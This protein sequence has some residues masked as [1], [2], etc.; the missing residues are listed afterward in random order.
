MTGDSGKGKLGKI[1]HYYKCF[2]KKKNKQICD[3]KS[4]SKD[5]LEEIVIKATQEFM[6]HTNL[7]AIAKAITDTYNKDIEKDKI[8][9]SLNKELQDNNKILANLLRALENG[10]FNDTTNARMKELELSNKELKEKIANRQMLTI[11]PLDEDVVFAFLNSFKDLNYS[12]DNAKQRLIDLFV[13]RVVLFDDHCEIY[14][15]VSNDK[16]TQLKLSE[17][18]DLDKEILFENKKQPEGSDC[19]PLAGR[20]RFR[21]NLNYILL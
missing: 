3:K 5:Y 2:T 17:Q 6:A 7:K 15:N 16:G 11:K 8:L 13:N 4:V 21:L 12:L 1:Y 9:E 18:P 10:I 19:Y 14:F 20:T